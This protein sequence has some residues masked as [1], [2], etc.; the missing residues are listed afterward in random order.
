MRRIIVLNQKGGVGKTTTVANLGACLAEQGRSVLMVDVDPQANLS[1]HFGI[2]L[3][4]GEP[5]IYTLVRAE[6]EPADVIRVTP[7]HGLH[8]VPACID[9]AGLSVELAGRPDRLLA[10]RKTL[11]GIP[12][13]FDYL[14]MDSAPSL[15]LLTVNAMCAAGEVFIPLQTEFFALQG[16]GKLLRTVRLV[17]RNMNRSLRITGVIAC[18]HDARTCLAQEILNEIR[19]HFGPRV[20]ETIIRKN[21]RLAEAPGFGQPITQ[22]DP[23]CHGAEDYRALAR[24]VLAMEAAL[25]RPLGQQDPV[26]FAR[27]MA[28]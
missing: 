5:S 9:L 15:G 3:E 7:V 20:F 22:Y 14:L 27:S 21:I 24:E 19:G 17:R 4:R 12:G 10:L 23:T 1:L 26:P 16:V 2:E 6:H 25:R 13:A 28:G 11:D 8:I 18:M